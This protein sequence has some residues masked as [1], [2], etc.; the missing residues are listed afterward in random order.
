ME[1]EFR[2]RMG[3]MQGKLIDRQDMMADISDSPLLTP[4][5]PPVRRMAIPGIQQYENP[6]MD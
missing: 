6:I 2:D 4:K 3:Q 5:D 1:N